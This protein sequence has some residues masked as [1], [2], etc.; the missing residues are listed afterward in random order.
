MKD[1]LFIGIDI[2]TQGTKAVLC[3]RNGG[4]IGE[5][6]SPSVLYRPD[7]DTVYENPENIFSS[8]ITVISEL[9]ARAG[10]NSRRICAIGMDAQMAGIMGIDR[11]F[12][13][14]IP[15]D[16]WL[17]GR[18]AEYT[19]FLKTEAGDEALESSGGQYI[20]AHAPKILWWKH[21]QPQAY[22]NTAKFIEPNCY[23]AGRLCGL[24]ADDAFMDYT[25][26]HFNVFSDNRNC[27]FR[28]DLLSH[29][30][31]SAEKMPRILPPETVIG[32][33]TAQF[34]AQCGL[35]EGVQVIA[36]CGDTAASSLGA[37]ITQPG[38]AYDVAGTASVFACC[39]DS[40]IPDTAH[41]TLLFSR[42]VCKNLFL[43]LSYINGGGL[44]LKWFSDI[45]GRSLQELDAQAAQ[46][47]EKSAPIFI[48]HL[49]GRTFPLDNRVSGAFLG[50][51]QRTD[52]GELYKAILEAIAFEYKNDYDIL[53]R[54]GCVNVRPTVIGV[55]GGAKSAVFSQIKADVLG[56]PYVTPQKTDSAPVA[57]ALLAA[58][59]VGLADG[60]LTDIFQPQT[61]TGTVYRPDDGAHRRYQ[62]KAEKY[63]RLLEHYGDYITMSDNG[64]T[65]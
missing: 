43:P 60:E 38:L 7:E 56:L 55:G 19:E 5:A 13:V 50:F 45:T 10:A 63:L 39:T 18:C 3:D 12:K 9:T 2:G 25:F 61:D 44:C 17:D 35:P 54:T 4:V 30:G 41:K 21:K 36:G 6:F 22:E 23:V 47:D 15:L 51:N 29:F 42:S 64:V 40:F 37:G 59:A 62:E 65:I 16:S 48:P 34:A 11:D 1:A 24:S 46:K 32:T 14:S 57:M 8:V 58:H 53:R 20:H 49:S 33:V 28:Q 31:V 27:R 52:A 26:L